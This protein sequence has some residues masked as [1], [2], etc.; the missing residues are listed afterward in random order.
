[1]KQHLSDSLVKFIESGLLDY[2]YVESE[3]F[4]VDLSLGVNPLGCSQKVKEFLDSEELDISS[5]PEVISG[6]LREKIAEVYGFNK[7]NILV[8][9]GAS[10][11]LH[12]CLL[13]F[14]DQGDEV[15]IPE[16]SFPPFELITIL[17]RGETKFIP[18]NTS[19]D[20]E[21]QQVPNLIRPRTKVVVF[22]NPNN[23]TGK[24][25]NGDEVEGLINKN[26][27]QVILI[28]EANIDFGGDSLI[29]LTKKYSNLLVIRSFSKG[30]GLA[31][32]RV[33]FV[34]GSKELIYALK[35]RQTPFVV[36]VVAQ[37][38]ALV[39]LDDLNFLKISREYCQKEREYLEKELSKLDWSF[40]PSHSNYLLVNVTS[41]FKNSNEFVEKVNNLGVGV[42]DG[43]NFRGLGG[44]FVRICPR[45]HE[46]NKRFIE[47]L[48]NIT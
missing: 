47:M 44:K 5:Y 18:F 11:L 35:R 38:T 33:G 4:P 41:R 46:I 32:L 17:V 30:F 15:I 14:I 39:A 29:N 23:P 31:G 26:Q 28:D 19:L 13:S 20:L 16:I 21:Y 48:R 45:K 2:A 24:K 3:G 42:V 10:E 6:S 37:K 25:L 27:N 22:C 7:E 1:M 40:I 43:D 8:G 36:N 34:V 12:L 9:A